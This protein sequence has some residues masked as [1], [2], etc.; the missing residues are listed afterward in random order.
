MSI[1]PTEPAPNQPPIPPDPEF[2]PVK[3]PEPDRLPDEVPEP[4]PDEN[5]ELRKFSDLLFERLA[6]RR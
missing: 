4:N 2:P 5:D 3:E 6:Q 1:I